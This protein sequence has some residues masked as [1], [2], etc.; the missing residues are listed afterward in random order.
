MF[1][2]YFPQGIAEG[3]A[4]LGR[5]EE[6]GRLADNLMCGRHTLLLAPRRYGKTSLA[7][8]EIRKIKYAH[9]EIDLFLAIDQRSIEARF[10]S[11]IEELIQKVSDTPSQWI[12]ALMNF[13]R[14]SEKKWTIGIKGVKLELKPE[15]H[16][17]I[18]GNI[19][20]SLQAL[21]H[22]LAKK[23]RR[24][25]IFIDEFQEISKIHE[26]KEIEGAVRH[27]AQ[28][29]KYVVFIFSGS[30]RHLLLDMFG[31]NS[32]PL[33][34][35]CDWIN[36]NRLE[37]DL[38]RRYL[39]KIANKT[40]GKPLEESAL[41]SIIDCTE[42]HPEY[43]YMLCANVWQQSSLKNNSPAKK[44]VA[45]AWDL[46]VKEHLKQ[47]RIMLS[48]LSAGQLKILIL[49]ALGY[50]RE[51]TGKVIQKKINITS[52]SI[53][54]ALNVLENQDMIEKNEDGSYRA[55]DPAVKTTL[56]NYY[57]DDLL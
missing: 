10:L 50:N 35:L 11:G 27:F 47:T 33:Y 20:L 43:V 28:A 7:R 12:H 1:N 5:K 37:P 22:V 4:F 32:R 56:V 29:S 46:Y 42:C 51:M 23:Q 57:R 16:H 48:N 13:F 6:A 26:G 31:D 2:R 25:A 39:N 19:L 17:D 49:I 21:E 55:I 24:A 34:S 3:E 45:N 18:A 9:T 44:D 30:S 36:L 8:H 38:Y 14:K 41:Q 15:D 40:W 53:V 52:P 54:A